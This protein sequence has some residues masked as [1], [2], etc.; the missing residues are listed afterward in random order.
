MEGKDGYY[1][2]PHHIAETLSGV[3]SAY[4]RRRLAVD[5]FRMGFLSLVHE[6]GIGIWNTSF[7]R[8]SSTPLA[9][10]SDGINVYLFPL[11][12]RL[13][14]RIATLLGTVG[15]EFVEE[16]YKATHQ[17]A[18]VYHNCSGFYEESRRSLYFV[19][20]CQDL[21]Y[22]SIEIESGAGLPTLSGRHYF[23]NISLLSEGSELA[24]L[25]KTLD[26]TGGCV[27][28]NDLIIANETPE[29][30]NEALVQEI[31]KS[32]EKFFLSTYGS[33][34]ETRFKHLVFG[35]VKDFNVIDTTVCRPAIVF[36][37]RINFN[38][39]NRYAAPQLRKE[40]FVIAAYKEA[41]RRNPNMFACFG[42]DA[43]EIIERDE[44]LFFHDFADPAE[45]L[46]NGSRFTTLNAMR[47]SE[48]ARGKLPTT[49]KEV[50]E[51]LTRSERYRTCGIA[52]NGLHLLFA[53]GDIS[54]LALKHQIGADRYA[55]IYS[56]ALK[57]RSDFNKA[58]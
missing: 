15:E 26:Y 50:V 25:I 22:D 7:G 24:K 17:I 10:Y 11:F 5:L 41:L 29:E 56:T 1:I 49:E 47:D 44:S 48:I 21:A 13:R 6:N 14:W 33:P 54:E 19:G 42:M 55:T 58:K 28:A 32:P 12:T 3:G 35:E 37:F 2:T 31:L 34:L 9:I 46:V 38:L 53:P 8:V 27:M 4:V 16:V 43:P 52:Y 20:I 45:M 57:S 36:G 39:T 23:Q 30:Q 40:R 51:Y 18:Q